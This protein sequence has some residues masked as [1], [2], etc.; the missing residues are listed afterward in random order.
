MLSCIFDDLVQEEILQI[1]EK[2]F[3]IAVMWAEINI[4]LAGG[5]IY[6]SDQRK[7]VAELSYAHEIQVL[8]LNISPNSTWTLWTRKNLLMFLGPL[9][10]N[11]SGFQGKITLERER[12]FERICL[13]NK[14]LQHGSILEIG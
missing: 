14:I 11:G 9:A 2:D 5:L 13:M 7:L 3:L 8:D 1:Y 10:L 4:L 12:I 6:I